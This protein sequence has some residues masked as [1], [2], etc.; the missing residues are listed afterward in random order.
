MSMTW[1][2]FKRHVDLVLE[3]LGARGDV[4][5]DW[6]DVTYPKV[7]KIG[8]TDDRMKCPEITVKI[9]PR[10]S[11]TDYKDGRAHYVPGRCSVSIS[12]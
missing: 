4:E 12:N 7:E 11:H 2:E 6:I 5:I 3:R 10:R 9:E 1:D 8:G